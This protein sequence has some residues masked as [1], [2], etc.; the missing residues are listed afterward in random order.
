[1]VF[2]FVQFPRYKAQ[3]RIIGWGYKPQQSR[4]PASP[5]HPKPGNELASERHPLD[6][7]SLQAG[8]FAPLVAAQAPLRCIPLYVEP[9]QSAAAPHKQTSNWAGGEKSV[10]LNLLHLAVA[11]SC[12]DHGPVAMEAASLQV[13]VSRHP[14]PPRPLVCIDKGSPSFRCSASRDATL[15]VLASEGQES[16]IL[17]MLA[18]QAKASKVV[19]CARA[20]PCTLAGVSDRFRLSIAEGKGRSCK[21]CERQGRG[22]KQGRRCPG[23]QPCGFCGRRPLS[24][25][26]PVSTCHRPRRRETLPRR[27]HR[28][29]CPE[30]SD[31]ACGTLQESS[32]DA[33]A[34]L[35]DALQRMDVVEKSPDYSRWAL[36]TRLPPHLAGRYSPPLPAP[37]GPLPVGCCRLGWAK[38]VQCNGLVISADAVGTMHGRQFRLSLNSRLYGN[39]TMR[40]NDRYVLEAMM[41]ELEE[42]VTAMATFDGFCPDPEAFKLHQKHLPPVPVALAA[43][44][45]PPPSASQVCFQAQKALDISCVVGERVGSSSAWLRS[46]ADYSPTNTMQPMPFHRCLKPPRRHAITFP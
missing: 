6:G 31:A 32:E 25:S 45:R 22:Q 13:S 42:L 24:A 3:R 23:D 18:D 8:R 16:R 41:T 14:Q 10:Q 19:I 39:L 11:G 35:K 34:E 27:S 40:N 1:M 12:M 29:A 44:S 30:R 28:V 33:D 26:L 36:L 4:N 38:A 37:A 43:L 17:S 9:I 46:I 2:D 7:P 20:L 21:S 5:S 15:Q